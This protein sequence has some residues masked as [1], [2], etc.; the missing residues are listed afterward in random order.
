MLTVIRRTIGCCIG[1]NLAWHGRV[2][3]KAGVQMDRAD[4]AHHEPSFSPSLC[5]CF[6]V[7]TLT[8]LHETPLMR[9]VRLALFLVL[10]SIR[11]VASSL[12]LAQDLQLPGLAADAAAY[13]AALHNVVPAAMSAAARI[14]TGQR[15]AQA[16]A[17]GDW[18]HA[19]PLLKK[20]LGA[21]DTTAAPSLAL[22]TGLEQ[23][24]TPEHA[25]ALAAAWRAY[26]DT[27]SGLDQL[28]ALRVM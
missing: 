25:H 11:L 2:S 21:G 27:N 6:A 15:A 24:P 26:R 7:R 13:A 8:F 12:A 9:P 23:L 5:D 10:S 20:R 19:V 4:R 18:V 16:I 28:P 17:A 22:A 3:A 1:V 14:A